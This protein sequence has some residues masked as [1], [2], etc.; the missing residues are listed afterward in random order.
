MGP[1]SPGP[2]E[3]HGPGARSQ[4]TPHSSRGKD[5]HL[6]HRV[7]KESQASNTQ[8][9]RPI[10]VEIHRETSGNMINH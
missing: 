5:V 2:E 1:R 9:K 7:K 3:G 4:L 10:L 6:R 8:Q